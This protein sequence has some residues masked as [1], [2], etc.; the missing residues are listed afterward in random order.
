MNS[1]T[2]PSLD[3]SLLEKARHTN[4]KTI[5]RCP[6]CA[7]KGCDRKGEHL[8]IQPNGKFGCAKYSGDH[9]HRREIFRLVGIKSDTGDNFTTEQREEWKWQR[10]REEAAQR[11]RDELATEAR[12][13]AAAIR[14]KYAWS[15][16]DAFYSSPQKI[17][18]ELDQDP[19][20]FLRTLYRPHEL[21]WTGET[22]QSGEEHG[23]GRFRT[24]ADWQKTELSELGP[25]VSPATWQAGA[26][27]RAAGNVQ[28]SPFTVLDFDELDGKTP[29]TKAERDALVH[30]AL[31]VTR[32]LVEVCEA[33]L[34][35]IVHS[36]NKSLHV[37][38][39]TPDPAALDGLRDMAQA[40][41]IDAG[42]IAAPEHPARLPGQYHLKSGNRSRTLWL[43]EPM[44]L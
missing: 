2:N 42:L 23:Q 24:V 19:R 32:W 25:M 8:V 21:I 29:E 9:E 43:A 31:A 28:S 37:W 35:A 33:K 44:H 26:L 36:G 13:K 39:K 17:E 7:A 15:P 11:R 16:A 1:S 22:W 30:H 41:G 6:A 3:L 14:E 4:G 18:M 34:A 27:S 10:R 38:I 5:A 20:H 40:W 12:N